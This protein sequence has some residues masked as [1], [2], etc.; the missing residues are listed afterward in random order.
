MDEYHK[1]KQCPYRDEY[2]LCQEGYCIR[3]G[4]YQEWVRYMEKQIG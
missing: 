4:I 3:C 1:G 2:L